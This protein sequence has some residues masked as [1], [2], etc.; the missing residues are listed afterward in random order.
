MAFLGN[1][2]QFNT[3][4]PET[5]NI[6]VQR[7]KFY[8]EANGV[9]DAGKKRAVFLSVCGEQTFQIA[10][11]LCIPNELADTSFDRLIDLLSTHFNPKQSEIVQRFLFNK[12]NQKEGE[13]V[14]AWVAELRKI[15]GL[16]NYGVELERQIR[17]RI[18]CGARNEALQRR[19][20]SEPN[21]T[22]QMAFDTA[23]ATENAASQVVELRKVPGQSEINKTEVHKESTPMKCWRCTANHDPTACR[24]K[25]ADCRF[26]SKKGHIERACL[27]RR[28]RGNGNK[29]N[30][31]KRVSAAQNSSRGRSNERDHKT[32]QHQVK[33]E[34][35]TNS[36][37]GED[38]Y[39]YFGLHNV[40]RG[41]APYRVLLSVNDRQC[42]FEIDSGASFTVMAQSCF[43]RL[44]AGDTPRL[45]NIQLSLRDWQKK[46]IAILGECEV[47]V[48]F[49]KHSKTLPLVV[50]KGDNISLL[51]RNWF[52]ALGI[53]LSMNAVAT[54]DTNIERVL[55]QFSDVFDNNLGNFRGKPV[56]LEIDS[57]VRP[58]RLKARNVAFALRPKIEAEVEKLIRQGILEPC[59]NPTWTTPIVPVVKSDGSIRICAD[60][61]CTLNKALQDDPYPM[62][63]TQEIIAALNGAK[64]FAKLD[65]AQAYQQ[66]KVDDESAKLQTIITQRGT[67]MVRR[68]CFGIKVAPQIFQRFINDRLAGIPG[69]FPYY[70]D[71]LVAAGNDQELLERITEI[72][73]RFSEDGLKLKRSKCVFR[74]KG[75]EFLGF[76]ISEEGV[77]PIA[78]KVRNIKHA[79]TPT[80]K[81]ELQSFLGLLNFY[82]AFLKNKA[83]FAESLHRLLDN[84][85]P[86]NWTT[87]NQRTFEAVKELLSSDQLLVHYDARKEL[88]LTCDASPWAVGVVLS[89]VDSDGREA[90]IAFHSKTLSQA[91]RR[92]SQLDKEAL[93]I[94]VGVKKFHNYCY[95]RHF[96]IVTDHKPLLGIL[97]ENKP[98]PQ[99][100]SPRLV[101]WALFLSNY[102][103]KLIHK[104]GKDISHADA[105]SRLPADAA[106]TEYA[107]YERMG[108]VFM[109][110]NMPETPLNAERVAELTGRDPVMS[111]IRDFIQNGW[112]HNLEDGLEEEQVRPFK[113]RR[114]ELSTYKNCILWGTRV[115]IPP[116]IRERVLGI[117]HGAH[118]GM[119]RMKSLAR[120]YVWWPSMDQAIEN[121]VRHCEECQQQQKLP[122][123]ASI[124][125]WEWSEVPWSRVHIDH[126]G[127]FCGQ[128]FL[129]IVDAFSKWLEVRRVPSTASEHTIQCL[130][131]IFATH[132]IPEV[133]ISDNGTSF[134]SEAFQLW[135]RRNG[136]RHTRIAPYHPASNGQAERMVQETK[137]TLKKLSTGNWET[138]IARFLITQHITPTST[139]GLSPAELMFKRKIR[140]C[141]DLL[142]PSVVRKVRENQQKMMWA[143][144]RTTRT[145]DQSATVLARKFGGSD[146]PRWQQEQIVRQLGPVTYETIDERG[147]TQKR[148]V[149]H[150][151]RSSPETTEESDNNDSLLQEERSQEQMTRDRPEDLAVTEQLPTINQRPQ[152]NARLPEKFRDFVMTSR[153]GGMSCIEHGKPGLRVRKTSSMDEEDG[154]L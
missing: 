98:V 128:Q 52:E 31:G 85:V 62:P 28:N 46:D 69:C 61:K 137:K 43:E 58:I 41:E 42:E 71:I 21:L 87:E 92:Y 100:S 59:E 134:T 90:P 49:N 15:G 55:Q 95:G 103:Y 54:V 121:A 93:A 51:G 68:L 122:A 25:D 116:K 102:D 82:H 17:D 150:L 3:A 118:I 126:A 129:I 89:H 119:V 22:F 112:P 64:V 117:L 123:R 14:S 9:T 16:C 113:A 32:G 84:K 67:Y 30:E 76:Y 139:T 101:R 50:T 146:E 143:G 12:R 47:R 65:M 6:Y 109:L 18:V 29:A 60:Y 74:T 140:T 79:P 141:L 35:P 45:N 135:T 26:C 73:R 27:S 83:N 44:F 39:Y 145:F 19:L 108:E 97:G 138:K 1:I 66:L 70:D 120:S 38:D 40:G 37:D 136:I 36:D 33:S 154:R 147:R 20:L 142:Q 131:E 24:W 130:R 124:H 53:K 57:T 80:C 13:T 132:G 91:E 96:E 133:I 88:V 2:E 148:H 151:R 78:D 75:I 63:T 4:A 34:P 48:S 149:D 153:K 7:V 94:V 11:S 23:T 144:P 77:R 8:L 105:L 99:M 125:P 115:V 127:P 104:P 107:S 86:W 106:E 81:R 110:E 111:R 114:D 72:L 152:R 10:R 56:K 5:W